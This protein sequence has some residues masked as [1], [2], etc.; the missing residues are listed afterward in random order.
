MSHN[1]LKDTYNALPDNA[2]SVLKKFVD[3]FYKSIPDEDKPL[4]APSVLA[5]I[6]QTHLA[7]TRERKPGTPKVL[8]RTPSLEDGTRKGVR[9]IIDIVNDDMPFL[10]DSVAAEITRN[11]K[12]VHILVHPMLHIRRDKAGRFLDVEDK[13][14][15]NTATQSHIHIELQ[16]T[17][18]GSLAKRMEQDIRT[19]LS[20]VYYATRDWLAMREKLRECGKNIVRAPARSYSRDEVAEDVKFLD[21]LYGDNFTLLGYREYKF[22]ESKGKLSSTIIKGSSLGLLHDDKDPVYISE[23]E[24]GLTP[25]LQ[26]MRHGLPP[27]TISKVNRRSTVHRPVPLDSVAVKRFDGKGNIV[28]ESLFI[29]LFTS[30]TYS[31][32]IEDVPLLRRKAESIMLRSG[33]TPGSHD[34]KALRHIL[35]KF[36][37]DELFQTGEK[38]LLKTCVSIMRLQERQRIALYTRPDP[39]GRYVSCLVYV[40][41]DRYDTGV[42]QTIQTILEEEFQGKTGDFYANLDDSPL[43][44]VMF[45]VYIDHKNTSAYNVQKIERRLQ[46]AGRLWQ[47]RLQDALL[48][49][50]DS[51]DDAVLY[52]QKYGQAFSVAYCETYEPKQAI[53]DIRKIEEALRA[54]A[55]SLDLYRCKLCSPS[56]MRLKVYHPENPMILSDVLPV[57]ENMGLRAVSEMPFE[58]RPGDSEK[59][60][61]IHDFMLDI[62]PHIVDVSLEQVKGAFE[63]AFS[64]IWYGVAENDGLNQLVLGAGMNWREI[65]ILRSFVRYMRQMG[66]SFGTRYIEQA[67]TRNPKISGLIAAL[68]LTLHDPRDQDGAAARAEGLFSSIGQALEKVVS[69]DED[70]ILRCI[71]ALVQST[72]R[73][74]FFQ[75]DGAGHPKS[76]LSLKLDSSKIADLPRPVPY[77]EIFVYSPRMEGIHLRGDV[78]ARGGIRWSDRNEDFRT[79]ILGL[80]KAQQ[81]KNS[82]IVPMGAKGGF[83]LKKPPAAGD[84]AAF[85][86]EGI[87]CYKIL[88][89]GLLDI[90]DNRKGKKVV[91]PKSVVCRDGDDPYL[92]VAADKGTASFSDIANGLSQDYG[93]WLGDAFASGG[94]AGYDHKKMGITAR[95]AWESIKRHF[96]EINHDIQSK[97]FDVIGVGDMGGDVFGNGMLLSSHIRLIGAFNHMHIFCDPNPD[98]AASFAERKRLFEGVLGWGEYNAAKL[99]A[100]GRIFL[101]SEKS[102]KLT[103]EI[104]KRFDLNSETVAPQELIRAML[105]GRTDLLWF[106]GIG[107]YVKAAH[108]THADVGDKGNDSL[109]INAAEIRARVVGEGANLAVTQQGRIE[110]A[111]KG[112]YINADFIDNSGGVDSSDHEVNIKILTTDVMTNGK[113][114]MTLAARNKLLGEMTGEIEDLVLRNN[115]QQAQALSLMESQAAKKLSSHAQFID[116]LE[117]KHG[118]SRAVENL[119]DEEEIARRRAAGKGLTRP[120]LGVVQAYAKILFAKDLLATDIPDLPEMQDYWLVDY[121][122]VPLRKKFRAE[123]LTH[124]LR[125]EIVATT[126]ASSLVNRMGPTFVKEIMDKTGADCAAVAKSYL[127]VRDAF[128]IRTFWDR[129]E[130]L[131]NTVPAL[132]QIKAMGSMARM[133]ERETIWFLTRLGRAPDMA[134]DVRDFGKGIAALQ[135]KLDTVIP[136]D[137]ALT[138]RQRMEAG[139]GDGLPEDVARQVALIPAMV[140]AFDIIRTGIDRKTD[141]ILTA[142]VFFELGEYF[143]IDWL[144]RQARYMTAEDRWSV[145]AL[146]GLMDELHSS[147]AGLASHVLLQM[148]PGIRTAKGSLVDHWVE[149]H[150]PQARQLVPLF[151]DLRRV[152]N[153]DMAMLT[154]AVQRLRGLYGG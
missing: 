60:V 38:E 136:A 131:D 134:G 145:E 124:R 28:G 100:G 123:I 149:G 150:C 144:R 35:E 66:Y 72:L 50:M 96:R 133:I 21:Y 54:G 13:R 81:V 23:D 43:A 114:K 140:S 141:L 80:M 132:A 4:I 30:V 118:V 6:A 129:I 95:G 65:V 18:A 69:L 82:V 49:E 92:V 57:L 46:Q 142:R 55:L 41:R 93:F 77:R 125:R 107:T 116:D 51:E 113:H 53:F 45:I 70:R 62:D 79:E 143:H 89:C 128:D 12:L 88:V 64:R 117:R 10:V 151:A 22:G 91:K 52:G 7:L 109:R 122:P 97:P 83:V 33:F 44:R 36:P 39:F 37:R 59:S 152:G 75:T 126:M 153:M 121:F 130:S 115:Y 103:P 102:L 137:L 94:S 14:G 99:S 2:L 47:E 5:E 101:R 67:L 139:M 3:G 25:D 48:Q 71:A 19:I 20:D 42:R 17:V 11:Y 106:G 15:E 9:T 8:I 119:P 29:G 61:W 63:D 32:S 1:L 76:Y 27:L 147:Q 73:T 26:K 105:K 111:K 24:S 98:V 120:E 104:M 16:G 78:I 56:Q 84:R 127:I 148:G 154:V 74:N 87:A 34:H 31:R 40:P 68:F 108:E 85:L 135:K 146:N 86:A 110:F 112:G 58:V 90:T 138:I